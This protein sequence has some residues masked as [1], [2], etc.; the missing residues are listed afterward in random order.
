MPLF[1]V[2]LFVYGRVRFLRHLLSL[3]SLIF[4]APTIAADAEE[5]FVYSTVT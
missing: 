1:P 4:A 3:Q 5:V 2:P